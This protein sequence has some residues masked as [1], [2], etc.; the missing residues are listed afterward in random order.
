MASLTT[1]RQ[2]LMVQYRSTIGIGYHL[3]SNNLITN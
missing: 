1:A 3:N 2:G